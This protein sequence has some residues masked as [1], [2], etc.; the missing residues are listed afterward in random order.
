MPFILQLEKLDFF[1]AALGKQ[2]ISLNVRIFHNSLG[3]TAHMYIDM[4]R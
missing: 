2:N 4:N 3:F 1:S